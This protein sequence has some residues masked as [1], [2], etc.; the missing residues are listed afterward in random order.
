MGHMFALFIQEPSGSRYTPLGPGRGPAR[1][2]HRGDAP[3]AAGGAQRSLRR[4]R[5]F[6]CAA[7]QARSLPQGGLRGKDERCLPLHPLPRRP[8]GSQ[9]VA[10]GI[11]RGRRRGRQGEA[12]AADSPRTGGARGDPHRARAAAAA[13]PPLPQTRSVG[14]GFR[15]ETLPPP[16]APRDAPGA[17]A[18]PPRSAEPE[19]P[20]P[21]GAPRLPLSFLSPSLS[22][23]PSRPN[24]S[25]Q[26][27]PAAAGSAAPA[28][29][30]P[31]PGGGGERTA[32]T[33]RRPAHRLPAPAQAN[34]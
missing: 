33:T 31:R 12:V 32:H 1:A 10:P 29:A 19:Q 24:F 11:P 21:P 6:L 18:A 27:F 14:G 23:S 5:R 30:A 20:L 28:P 22:P 3:P 7:P 15:S 34:K 26:T 16:P 13:P 9:R 8:A 2:G 4:A 17:A 25:C